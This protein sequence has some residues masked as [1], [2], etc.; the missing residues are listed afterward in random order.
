[1]ADKLRG[2]EKDEVPVTLNEDF[3]N[4]VVID[5]LPIVPE[6]KFKKLTAVVNKIFGGYGK[7]Q[8]DG[9]HAPQD[10]KG[11]TVGF[12]F[13]A[14]E[15]AEMAAKALKEGDG[16]KLDAKHKF[17]VS[18]WDDFHKYSNYPEEYVAPEKVETDVQTNP[19]HW[20]MDEAGRD[21]FVVRFGS[22]THV[23][24]NDPH[25]KHNQLGRELNN[26]GE[27]EKDRGKN[28]TEQYCAWSTHGMYLATFHKQGIALWGGGEFVKVGR[29]GHQDVS[30]IDFSPNDRYL[31]TSNGQ[32]RKQKGDPYCIQVWDI[33]TKKLLRGFDRGQSKGGWPAFKWSH[34]DK[35]IARTTKDTVSVYEVPSMN[36]LGSKSFKIPDVQECLWSPTQNILAYWVPEKD[37][38]PAKVALME[39]PSRKLIREK[40]L[41]NVAD[42]KL[43]WQASGDYLCV[44]L[45][46]KKTK[47]TIVHNFE[48]FRLRQK[49]VPV[50]VLEIE[51]N[52][53]AFAWEPV[54]SRFAII[55]GNPARPN[56]S[57]YVLQKTKLKLLKTLEQRPAN[58]LYWSPTGDFLVVAGLGDKNGWLEFI[59][60]NDLDHT[61]QTEH[62]MCTD[63]EWDP[64]GRYVISS[65]TQPLNVKPMD[66]RVTM[67]NGYIL[68]SG[69]GVQLHKVPVDPCYQVLWRPRPKT[70]FTAKQIEGIKDSLKEKYWKQFEEEDAAT[71][72]SQLSG[73]AKER[74]DW[75]TD[76]K[77]F[78]ARSQQLHAEEAEE[79]RELRGGLCSD[80]E[81]D[82]I[83]VMQT[84]EEE[85]SCQIVDAIF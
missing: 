81:D 48:I 43:H 16:K 31:V 13:V 63:V 7:I 41:Y 44:K 17:R 22:D 80:D 2:F 14:Y 36:L 68:W 66:F 85:I 25:R 1:M 28:W 55:H 69:T 21:Q 15:T 19:T 46:R 6:S 62:H 27:R 47:K 53:L 54:G 24:W 58:C 5:N 4:I 79:R 37:N 72:Q 83:D 8:E 34:D 38:I 30:F 51:D 67:E 9:L 42:V 10:E 61:T 78:V 45:A 59:N 77:S 75:K 49:N 57:L 70:L 32:D 82:F 33:R 56:V 74:L 50:E 71:R 64:S 35:Y 18:M 73:E 84:E 11:S 23:Y 26:G 40:H 60:M 12:C 65:V 3:R 52:I 20:L 29:F 39:I 76:W